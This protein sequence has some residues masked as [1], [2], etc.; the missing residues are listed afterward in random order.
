MP[1]ENLGN[2]RILGNEKPGT[3]NGNLGGENENPGRSKFK[4][5]VGGFGIFGKDIPGIRN[6][7]SGTSKLHA[8]IISPDRFPLLRQPAVPLSRPQTVLSLARPLARP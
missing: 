5:S 4:L 6:L 7:T 2:F 8:D 1:I 3:R